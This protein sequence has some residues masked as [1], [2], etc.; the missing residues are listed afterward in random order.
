[1]MFWRPFWCFFIR[2]PVAARPCQPPLLPFGFTAITDHPH[3]LPECRRSPAV[4]WSAVRW[5]ASQHSNQLIVVGSVECKGGRFLVGPTLW[6]FLSV[7]MLPHSSGQISETAALHNTS[8]KYQERW[9]YTSHFVKVRSKLYG[10]LPRPWFNLGYVKSSVIF[11]SSAL[12]SIDPIWPLVAFTKFFSNSDSNLPCYSNSKFILCKGPLPVGTKFF[13]VADTR[14]LKVRW[15]RP[16]LL[17]LIYLHLLS[18]QS[19]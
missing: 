6:L 13:V 14:D 17:L 8:A 10:R 5:S 11:S 19:L 9:V 4:L 18:L 3:W 16:W 12:L 7:L 15:Y 2:S 1:M